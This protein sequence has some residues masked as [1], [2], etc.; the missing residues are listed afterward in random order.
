[1]SSSF[2]SDDGTILFAILGL[3]VRARAVRDGISRKRRFYR[4]LA[5]AR[6]LDPG[7]IIRQSAAYQSSRALELAAS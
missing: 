1:M 3:T 2:R 5:R 6:S 7:L 4:D